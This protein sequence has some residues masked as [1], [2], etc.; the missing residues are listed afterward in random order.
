MLELLS[1]HHAEELKME[2]SQRFSFE[3]VVLILVTSVKLVIGTLRI[4]K[5]SKVIASRCWLNEY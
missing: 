3:K 2:T 1:S 4:E 5:D